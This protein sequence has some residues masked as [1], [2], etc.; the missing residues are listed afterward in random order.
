[1]MPLLENLFQKL[2]CI[3]SRDILALLPVRGTT[4]G[5]SQ[6]W[7]VRLDVDC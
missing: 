5:T 2:L 4:A 7:D 1:M 6:Y 3:M